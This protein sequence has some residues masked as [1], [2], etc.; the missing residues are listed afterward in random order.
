ME[1]INAMHY[2]IKYITVIIKYGYVVMNSGY[3]PA[4]LKAAG[5]SSA[6]IVPE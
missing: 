5:S 6:P 3:L 2:I 4:A 1:Y